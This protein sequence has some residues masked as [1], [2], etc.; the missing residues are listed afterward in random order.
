VH[1]GTGSRFEIVLGSMHTREPTPKGR[2]SILPSLAKSAV[3]TKELEIRG[4]CLNW[5]CA[6]NEGTAR[7]SQGSCDDEGAGLLRHVLHPLHAVFRVGLDR[8][9]GVATRL[10][11]AAQVSEVQVQVQDKTLCDVA[12]FADKADNWSRLNRCAEVQRYLHHDTSYLCSRC[13][14]SDVRR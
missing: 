11:L 1:T 14:K 9:D 8:P 7:L 12:R 13:P 6:E 10:G 2:S 4:L 5:R 3:L